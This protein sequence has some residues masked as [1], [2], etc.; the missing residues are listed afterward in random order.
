GRSAADLSVEPRSQ[1]GVRRGR[2]MTMC[3]C[4][5]LALAAAK[6]S[7]PVATFS[8]VARDPVTGDM[9]VAV[10]SHWFSVG[11]VVT[12]AEAGI[13]AV[14]TQSFVEPS[15]GK[16]GLDLIRGGASAPDGLK[17]LLAKDDQRGVRQVA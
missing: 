16:H 2:T 11:S 14:A 10:Q 8:I 12:W 15:Y 3:G 17:Q 4:L 7:M 6:P 9:G 5:L 13:G 1:A